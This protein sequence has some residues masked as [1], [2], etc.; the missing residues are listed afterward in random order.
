MSQAADQSRPRSRLR[1]SRKLPLLA[2][3]GGA[4]FWIASIATSLL[5]IA[6]EY[7]AA[8][9]NWSMQTVWIFSLPMGILIGCCV[10][11]FL[12]RFFDRI[13]TKSP[14][15]KSVMLSA[16][17]LI[18][19]IILIDMPMILHAHGAALYYFLIGVVFN[20]IRF[21]LLGIAVGYLYQKLYG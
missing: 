3:T 10:G 1:I 6:A 15:L 16:V 20:I 11:Y 17:A 4:V 12:L 18:V 7:R 8:F 9:S 14:I 19:A 2:V 21:L 13:P 5:P